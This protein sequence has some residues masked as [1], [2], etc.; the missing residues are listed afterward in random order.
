MYYWKK[1]NYEIAAKAVTINKSG[2]LIPMWMVSITFYGNPALSCKERHSTFNTKEDAFS[3]VEEFLA[4]H[5]S[6]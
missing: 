3:H 5:P 2:S 6:R 1:E 4:K